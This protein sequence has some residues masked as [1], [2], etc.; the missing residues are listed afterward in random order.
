MPVYEM[1]PGLVTPDRL[2]ATFTL[3]EVQDALLEAVRADRGG[4][5]PSGEFNVVYRQ[6]GVPDSKTPLPVNAVVLELTK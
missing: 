1:I 6:G 3:Q 2:T 5:V 4:N